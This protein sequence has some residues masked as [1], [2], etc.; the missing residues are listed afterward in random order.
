MQYQLSL[1]MLDLYFCCFPQF[2]LKVVM[3][4]MKNESIRIKYV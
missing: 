1:C 2:R 4:T 3:K